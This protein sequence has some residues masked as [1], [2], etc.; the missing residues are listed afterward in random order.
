M[1]EPRDHEAGARLRMHRLGPARLRQA[2]LR[3]PYGF[4]DLARWL[5]DDLDGMGHDTAVCGRPLDRRHGGARIRPQLPRAPRRP[6]PVRHHA[7]LRQPRRHLRGQ[8]SWPTGSG[9][10]M[11]APAWPILPS[12][13][14]RSFWAVAPDPDAAREGRGAACRG[15]R[16]RLSPGHRLPRHLR[17]ARGARP[18]QDA[19]LADRRRGGPQRPAQDHGAHGDEHAARRHRGVARR[20]PYGAAGSARI[21]LPRR[22]ATSSRRPADDAMPL[23]RCGRARPADLRPR[24]VPAVGPGGR[25]DGARPPPRQ[26]ALRPA[27]QPL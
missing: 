27:R 18:D 10:S 25:T 9:P 12:A 7:G 14:R 13:P 20:R 3:Q 1:F 6:D 26:G 17:P 2:P 23:D 21:P 8:S 4:A 5:A 15:A 16:R 22:F 19:H 11:P 24:V